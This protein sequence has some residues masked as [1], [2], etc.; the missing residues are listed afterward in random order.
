MR[1]FI[2]YLK[3]LFFGKPVRGEKAYPDKYH[4]TSTYPERRISEEGWKILHK[5]T[6]E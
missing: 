1:K 3:H 2:N 4:F 6:E 5:V